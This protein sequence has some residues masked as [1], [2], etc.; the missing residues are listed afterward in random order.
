MSEK[1]TSLLNVDMSAS[2][3]LQRRAELAWLGTAEYRVWQVTSPSATMA[4][5][6]VTPRDELSA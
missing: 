1:R 4:P 6:H 2:P 5:P 3:S